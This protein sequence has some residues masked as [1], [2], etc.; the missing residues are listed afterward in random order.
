[1][2]YNERMLT[3]VAQ[4][5]WKATLESS[6][7]DTF[8]TE[9]G[10]PM[11]SVHAE[12]F[13]PIGWTTCS[14]EQI[15]GSSSSSVAGSNI[16][17]V[18]YEVASSS[19]FMNAIHMAIPVPALELKEM[20][21]RDYRFKLVDFFGYKVVA[22]AVF[23]SGSTIKI[24][25]LDPHTQIFLFDRMTP[26]GDV[27]ASLR[28]MGAELECKEWTTV[29]KP[30]TL[31]YKQQYYFSFWPGKGFPLYLV[32][33]KMAPHIVI[34]YVLDMMKHVV[35]K[36]FDHA[37]CKWVIEKK[38]NA[39]LF[40]TRPTIDVPTIYGKFSNISPVEMEN[41][42][43]DKLNTFYILDMI[44]CDMEDKF[45]PG[46]IA[47]STL[48]DFNGLVQVVFWALENVTHQ[49]AN[50]SCNYTRD[51]IE[52]INS[53]SAVESVT[54]KSNSMDKCK[55][56][57]PDLLNELSQG[58]L[59]NSGC[60]NGIMIWPYVPKIVP[61]NN[62]GTPAQK[63]GTSIACAIELTPESKGNR[64]MLRCRALVC[65]KMIIESGH[66]RIE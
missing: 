25:S 47:K 16:S 17:S 27:E 52:H 32:A 20:Y 58:V 41:R 7:A 44:N 19:S 9:P 13:D 65:K 1:M 15:C 21:K 55:N 66:I 57:T 64:Y 39:D 60:K 53:K 59:P 35:V 36:R 24:Q 18:K 48:I 29:L 45:K 3:G 50:I 23:G 43:L 42:A 63:L 61:R 51:Q 8:V 12:K 30:T 4:A 38:I 5:E 31:Y 54:V 2:L 37:L 26:I 56:I 46:S 34:E 28:R 10:E 14:M 6:Y 22:N 62:G 40:T 49:D 11:T 33:N